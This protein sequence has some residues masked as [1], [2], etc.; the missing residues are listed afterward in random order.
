MKIRIACLIIRK[1]R[2]LKILLVGLAGSKGLTVFM[3]ELD[4]LMDKMRYDCLQNPGTRQLKELPQ[5]QC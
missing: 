5:T 2:F 4:A 1:I 3:L